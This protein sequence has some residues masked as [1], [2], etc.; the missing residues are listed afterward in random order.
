MAEGPVPADV[1]TL[2]AEWR[3]GDEH[4]RDRLVSI[5]YDQLRRIAA[6]N[7]RNE[8]P[9]HTMQATELV[10]EMY[11]RLLAPGSVNPVDRTHLFAIAARQMRRILVDHA[12]SRNAQKRDVAMLPDL[13]AELRPAASPE[14]LLVVDHVLSQLAELDE[15]AAQVVEFRFFAGA[16]EHE[17]AEALGI[18][19]NTVK[20][21]WDFA[22]AW[23]YKAL[24]SKQQSS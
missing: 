5:V 23:L 19:V 14:D 15:R 10:N 1:T 7:L 9:A 18:S 8:A 17:T 21:D 20:R 11:L 2:L 12:R 3:N 24:Q 16:T 13:N 22:R 4:A 6:A